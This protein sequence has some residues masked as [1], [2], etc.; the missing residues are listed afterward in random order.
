MVLLQAT[1]IMLEE[2]WDPAGGK[3]W[4]LKTCCDENIQSLCNVFFIKHNAVSKKGGITIQPNTVCCKKLWHIGRC[5]VYLCSR[6][7]GDIQKCFNARQ[8]TFSGKLYHSYLEIRDLWNHIVNEYF[9]NDNFDNQN[10]RMSGCIFTCEHYMKQ[11]KLKKTLVR[12]D[13]KRVAMDKWL[14]RFATFLDYDKSSRSKSERS[15]TR[16][17]S[18]LTGANYRAQTG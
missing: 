16:I 5:V 15:A 14:E 7:E 11:F 12:I 3:Y 17:R 9:S 4:C 18:P 2:L 10:A 1:Y 8:G 13:N 6:Q